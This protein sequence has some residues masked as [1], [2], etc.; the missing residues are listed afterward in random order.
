VDLAIAVNTRAL[1][2][3]SFGH[4]EHIRDMAVVTVSEGLGTGIFL[5]GQL[6]RGTH[7]TAGEFGHVSLDPSGPKCSCGGNGCWEVFASNRAALR[8]NHDSASS[9][10]DLSFQDLLTLVQAEVA[11]GVRFGKA[12]RIC[13]AEGNSARSRGTVALVLQKHFGA[14]G[15]SPQ[16]QKSLELRKRAL[17]A[18]AV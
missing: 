10:S 9:L 7:G 15:S 6:M 3:V 8:Y 14:S 4:K 11:A 18:A 5:S 12:T 2:E 13:A 17:G 16:D 1:A